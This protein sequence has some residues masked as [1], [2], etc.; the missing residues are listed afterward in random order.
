MDYLQK[1]WNKIAIEAK[2]AQEILPVSDI[3]RKNS[4]VDYDIT[5]DITKK[6]IRGWTGD[7]GWLNFGLIYNGQII[8]FAKEQCPETIDVLKKVSR[9]YPIAVAG[10]S[11][12]KGKCGIPPH[13]DNNPGY[14]T[15]H[16]GLDVPERCI[17]LADKQMLTHQNGG[18]IYF[19]SNKTHS[20]V[21]GSDKDRMVLYLLLKAN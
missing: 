13:T 9:Y 14:L 6:W 7:P 4:W 1:D 11:L 12:L 8:P 20:A 17:I 18:I 19:D 3:V 16:L 2:I 15:V 5:D 10:F 21:N